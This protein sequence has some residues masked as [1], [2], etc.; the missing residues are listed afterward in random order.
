LPVFLGG[1]H[2]R[3]QKRFAHLLR[4]ENRELLE[5][6]RRHVAEDWAALTARC[7]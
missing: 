7:V 5:Q 4:P 3:P 2:L 6:V 1:Q